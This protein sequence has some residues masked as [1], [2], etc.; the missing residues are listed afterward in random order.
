MTKQEIKKFFLEQVDNP[1]ATWSK[2]TD[3]E[4]ILV[5]CKI[6]NIKIRTYKN[7]KLEFSYYSDAFIEASD[8]VSFSDIGISKFRILFP[9]FGITARVFRR[10]KKENSV[11]NKNNTN[12]KL[13][14][15]SDILTKDKSLSRDSKI[16]QILN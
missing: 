6:G 16:N 13:D 4:W 2:H 5:N 1:N 14:S 12:S 11:S 7:F 3:G 8:I 10:I 15:V 9:Y